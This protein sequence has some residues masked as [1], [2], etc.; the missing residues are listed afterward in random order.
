MRRLGLILMMLFVLSVALCAFWPPRTYAQPPEALVRFLAE[1]SQGLER[2]MQGF[3]QHI[4]VAS[5]AGV[6]IAPTAMP[7]G[8]PRAFPEEGRLIGSLYTS[9]PLVKFGLKRPGMYAI[10][11]GRTERGV[12]QAAFL[13]ESGL[14]ASV[15]AVDV[16]GTEVSYEQPRAFVTFYMRGIV[17]CWSQ[18][19]VEI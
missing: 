8:D 4:D 5:L 6:L 12:W 19:C 7:P 15:F 18:T 10:R 2:V 9:A 3:K 14:V 1:T 16:K 17:I 11:L 13:N